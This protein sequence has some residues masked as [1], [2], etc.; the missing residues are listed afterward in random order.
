MNHL[1]ASFRR[2]ILFPTMKGWLYGLGFIVISSLYNI[3]AFFHIPFRAWIYGG[4]V[5]FLYS[6][7]RPYN[8]TLTRFQ[9][10]SAAFV[11]F[12]FALTLTVG[13]SLY[14]CQNFSLC[15]SQP[16]FFI[17]WIIQIVYIGYLSYRLISLIIGYFKS[18]IVN[19]EIYT[20]STK[21]L[22]LLFVSVRLIYF[23]FFYPC[24]FGYDAAVGM[25]SFLDP[26][27]ARCDHHPFLV[28]ALHGITFVLGDWLG[29]RSLGFAILCLGFL[30]ATSFILVY[31]IK[32]LEKLCVGRINILISVFVYAAF[33]LYPYLSVCPNK[34]GIFAYVFLLYI[35]T[36]FELYITHGRCWNKRSFIV[37]HFLSIILVCITRH[38]GLYI[39]LA[40]TLLLLFCYWHQKKIFARV[41]LPAFLLVAIYFKLLL[42]AM[43]VEPGGKQEMVGV[44]FQQTANYLK[45]YPLDVTDEEKN[46]INTILNTDTIVQ[47]YTYYTIDPVKSTYKYNPWY[48]E[49]NNHP[50]MFRHID[51]G[52][53]SLALLEY[54]RAWKSM[55]SRHPDAYIEASVSVFIGF[56]YSFNRLLLEPEPSW[57]E[58]IGA[59]T[60]EYN[61]YHVNEFAAL[62]NDFS[63]KL[64]VIPIINWFVDVPFYIW[65]VI[66]ALSIIIGSKDFRRISVCF[67]IFLSICVL[68]MCPMVYGRYAYPVIV[69]LPHLYFLVRKNNYNNV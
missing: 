11:S 65:I 37:L 43:N 56:F 41:F 9:A 35:F 50:S 10:C 1:L 55:G 7:L 62:I 60:P 18:T 52:G 64:L 67:P 51:H 19:K 5:V 58:N 63:Y 44:F 59:I 66:L 15:F 36:L 54:F 23:A 33:P 28:E 68:L 12:L 40:E 22:F 38:Q 13:N 69:A 31:G 42:P 32:L 39:V 30:I 46:A 34:D 8:K 26:E 45:H 24:V 16:T 47:R 61:F 27:C 29:H 17:V 57:S 20:I 14:H 21:R 49:S 3:I 53:E 4:F 25:R 2:V 6:F 48:R